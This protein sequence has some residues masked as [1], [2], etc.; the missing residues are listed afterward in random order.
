[1]RYQAR[2]HASMELR[3]VLASGAATASSLRR[4]IA[5]FRLLHA[6]A[7]RERDR[8]PRRP[9]LLRKL[10]SQVVLADRTVVHG[11]MLVQTVGHEVRAATEAEERVGD[12]KA[13]KF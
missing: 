13:G 11:R 1:M 2:P 3:A 8:G 5:P 10:G 6:G 9:C 12:A 7:D 4:R